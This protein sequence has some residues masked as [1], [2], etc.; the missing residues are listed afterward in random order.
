VP[1]VR[2]PEPRAGVNMG[3]VQVLPQEEG[4]PDPPE[5]AEVVETP[6]RAF[7]RSLPKSVP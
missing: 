4:Y 2:P 7:A 3:T 6:F 1:G 5:L